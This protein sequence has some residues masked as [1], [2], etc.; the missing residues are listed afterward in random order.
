MSTKGLMRAPRMLPLCSRV[1][2]ASSSG[3]C[4]AMPYQSAFTVL[5]MLT[6]S[7]CATASVHVRLRKVHWDCAGAAAC[8]F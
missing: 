4:G 3:L 5:E 1:L 2:A 7:N 8:V 6:K